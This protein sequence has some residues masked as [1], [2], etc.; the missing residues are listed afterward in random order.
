MRQFFNE[1][2]RLEEPVRMTLFRGLADTM[3]EKPDLSALGEQ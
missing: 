2:L 1:A 3:N